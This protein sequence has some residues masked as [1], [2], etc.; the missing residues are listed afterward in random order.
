MKSGFEIVYLMHE[1]ECFMIEIYGKDI[2]DLFYR[3]QSNGSQELFSKLL[4]ELMA[5]KEIEYEELKRIALQNLDC[6]DPFGIEIGE[7][8]IRKFMRIYNKN[9]ILNIEL[10]HKQNNDH[11]NIYVFLLNLEK[12]IK[13]AIKSNF[14]VNNDIK[15]KIFHS[16]LKEK[17]NN[18]LVR[19]YS[20][21]KKEIFKKINTKKFPTNDIK[22]KRVNVE[23]EIR[24]LWITCEEYGILYNIKN[25]EVLN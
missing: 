7:N 12:N 23:I 24:T 18:V 3:S 20:F 11:H 8:H 19:S 4:D 1:W 17:D 21:G 9:E 14:F 6:S 15:S 10:K 22:G 2:T 13:N 25:I 5:N 16:T